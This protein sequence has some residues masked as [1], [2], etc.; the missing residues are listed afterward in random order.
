[1]NKHQEKNQQQMMSV[2]FDFVVVNTV[3][4]VVMLKNEDCT[5]ERSCK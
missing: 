5:G 2:A 4:F 1:M 3:F